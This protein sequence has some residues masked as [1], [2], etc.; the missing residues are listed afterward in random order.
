MQLVMVWFSAFQLKQWGLTALHQWLLIAL[1]PGYIHSFIVWAPPNTKILST[2][3][4]DTNQ[5]L[6]G[7]Q[8][9]ISIDRTW[10][11]VPGWVPFKIYS[12][13]KHRTTPT[14]GYESLKTYCLFMEEWT[15]MMGFCHRSERC[16]FSHSSDPYTFTS[17][18]RGTRSACFHSGSR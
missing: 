14:F 2:Q 15:N 10:T 4:R 8:K 5:L 16:M 12:D 13:Y 3:V 1:S 9:C 7:L 6:S 18:D 17:A 11:K